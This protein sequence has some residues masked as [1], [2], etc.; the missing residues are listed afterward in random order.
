MKN[1]I[2]KEIYRPVSVLPIISKVFGKLMQNQINLHIKSFL[3]PYLCGYRKGFNSQIS[4]KEGWWKSLDNNGYRGA[5][6]MD[7]FKDFD[8][9][10]H[11]LLIAKLHAY[12]F[13]IKTLTLLAPCILESCSWMKIKLNF[14]F[15]TSLWCL[16]RFYEGLK[17]LHKTFWD[18][19]KKC[20]NKN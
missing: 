12:G 13:D 1:P 5:V 2:N 9:L 8:T 19:T 20:K 16:K 3:S 18:T 6:L 14:Y 17:G 10:N 7:L 11:D 4:F 15:H